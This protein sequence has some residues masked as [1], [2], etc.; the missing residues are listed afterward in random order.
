[1][2][3]IGNAMQIGALNPFAL[4]AGLALLFAPASVFT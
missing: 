2:E 3:T 1:M 4:L